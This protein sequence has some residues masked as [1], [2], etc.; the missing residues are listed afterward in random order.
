MVLFIIFAIKMV[1][2]RGEVPLIVVR[3]NKYVVIESG[4]FWVKSSA[5]NGAFYYFCYKNGAFS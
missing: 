3:I 2:F 1:L 4:A 5:N